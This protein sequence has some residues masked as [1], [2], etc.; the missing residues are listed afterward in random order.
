METSLNLKVDICTI[1]P[2]FNSTCSAIPLFLYALAAVPPKG[3][4]I[5]CT[6][7]APASKH[8]FTSAPTTHGLVV[9]AYS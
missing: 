1:S 6:L 2:P 5:T 7:P 4:S 9:D 8:I 3:E